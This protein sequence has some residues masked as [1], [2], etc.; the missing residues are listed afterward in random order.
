VDRTNIRGD[1]IVEE[2]RKKGKEENIQS[3]EKCK[4]EE[5]E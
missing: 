1:V 5:I 3:E 4:I 2:N